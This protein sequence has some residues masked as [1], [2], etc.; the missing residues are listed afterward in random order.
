MK[1]NAAFN[2]GHYEQ[3]AKSFTKYTRINEDPDALEKRGIAFMQTN[4]LNNAIKD[5][6]KAKQL[7]NNSPD[8]FLMMGKIKQQL[9]ELQEA[10][11]F[12]QEFV[13]QGAELEPSKVAF[14]KREIKNC[15]FTATQSEEEKT[16]N[17]EAFDDKVNTAFD[18]IKPIQ[19]PRYGNLFYV[20]SNKNSSDFNIHA[21]EISQKG[22]W[23]SLSDIGQSLNTAKHDLVQDI[24]PSGK[25]MLFI[26]K[27]A[28]SQDH[29]IVFSTFIDDKQMLIEIPPSVLKNAEDLQIVNHK[30]LAF[31]STSM[32]G[33]GGYDIFT[34]KYDNNT[35]GTPK[36]AGP[37][38]NSIYDD[39]FPYYT[40][41]LKAVF[42]S[43]N[44]PYCFGGFD[45]YYQKDPRNLDSAPKNMGRPINGPG[46]DINFRLHADGNMALFSSNRRIA[47]GGFDA[48]FAY[49]RDISEL[50]KQD[51][52]E[53]GFILDKIKEREMSSEQMAA[54]KDT[55]HQVKT[56]E[57][58]QID[59]EKEAEAAQALKDEI[60]NT[61]K[62]LEKPVTEITVAE[63]I[64]E[65]ESQNKPIEINQDDVEALESYTIFYQDRHDLHNHVNNRIV[66]AIAF[67]LLRSEDL[68]A[69]LFSYTDYQEPGLPEFVQYNTLLKAETIADAILEYGVKPDQIKIE[70]LASN[71]PVAKKEVAGKL[72]ED[73]L[74]FNKRIDVDLRKKSGQMVEDYSFNPETLPLA[75]RDR[76]YIL[77]KDIREELYY[78]VKVASSPRI[79]KNA[80]LRL[81][82]DIYI[83]KEHAEANNDYYIGIYTNLKD[84]QAL[85]EKL[86]NSTAPLSELVAFYNGRIVQFEDVEALSAEYPDLKAYKFNS[87][88]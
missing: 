37:A 84:A 46:D 60:L 59:I 43:S 6:T 31:S 12:Y 7:G 72:N 11:F 67:K 87:N 50:P 5:F 77:F 70:S 62:E 75:S 79:F 49:M 8:L 25:T 66:Q 68:V 86:H 3:A 4:K 23:N 58:N 48:F 14:A 71:F 28:E 83:R 47:K 61:Q 21:Y 32:G 13:A 56:E 40:S 35:W 42:F 51:S 57:E 24:S 38:V 41:N 69:T 82:N 33:L 9:N 78:S 20:T 15:L 10:T 16:A 85:K 45:I 22:A 81:Y 36:N 30:T 88:E 65:V 55:D 80:I 39:R 76:K 63:N 29:T 34:I 44:R 64:D 2:K 26:K 27:G 19:S 74:Y 53:F 1:A 18:E 54:T 17:I 73:Q 52:L